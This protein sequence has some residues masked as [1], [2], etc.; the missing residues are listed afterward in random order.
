MGFCCHLYLPTVQ[1]FSFVFGD[2][3]PNRVGG[4]LME[5]CET[6]YVSSKN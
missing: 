5:I 6:A 2:G 4:S 1:V 3:D